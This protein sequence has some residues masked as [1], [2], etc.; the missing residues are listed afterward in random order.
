MSITTKNVK[1][2]KY[3]YFTYYDSQQKSKRE[4][5][6]GSTNDPK[7]YEKAQAL[8][9][10]L[11]EL[12]KTQIENKLKEY[13]KSTYQKKKIKVHTPKSI[14]LHLEALEAIKH[15]KMFEPIIIWIQ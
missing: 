9:Q 1:G 5:Y 12:H 10:E 13:E 11:L 4:Q 8:K 3:V 7:S 2:A 14:T 15:A 6:C